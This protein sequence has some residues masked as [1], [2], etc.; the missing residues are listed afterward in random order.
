MS[1]EIAGIVRQATGQAPRPATD[2]PELRST[3]A[4]SQTSEQTN[5]TQQKPASRDIDVAQLAEELSLV[6]EAFQKRL[7]FSINREL[8]MVVVKVIDTQTDKVI[9]ELPPEEIQRLHVR[10]REAIGLLIDEE[11]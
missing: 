10:I 7:K 11:I 2:V 8:E 5:S 1:M 6:T 3:S 4:P 9:K